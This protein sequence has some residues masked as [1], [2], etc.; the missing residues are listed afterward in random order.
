LQKDSPPS[1]FDPLSLPSF[2]GFVLHVSGMFILDGLD[3][4]NFDDGGSL[5]FRFIFDFQRFLVVGI[6]V[7][8]TVSVE[9]GCFI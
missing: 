2:R 8:S 3:S 6:F 1:D 9:S 4:T 5:C 7:A